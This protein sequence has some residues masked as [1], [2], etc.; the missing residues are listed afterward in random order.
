MASNKPEINNRTP[1]DSLYTRFDHSSYLRTKDD[2]TEK[3]EPRSIV[4]TTHS[5]NVASV[6]RLSNIAVLRHNTKKHH[7]T[8]H[9]LHNVGRA[10]KDQEREDIERYI[11]V[12]RGEIFFSKGVI[13]V[14]GDAEK[15]MLP[16]LAK[17]YD[18][19]FDFDALG[20]TVCSISGTN[21]GPYVQLLGPKGL[22]IPFV[23]LTDFDPKSEE[24]SQEDADP[25][26]AGVEDCYGKN[27][28]VNQIMKSLMDEE[29]WNTTN[30]E[31]IIQLAPTHGVF[32]NTFTFEI[33]LFKAGAH[34]S[35][36]HAV[37]EL[38]TN[39]KMHA[40]FLELSNDS[41]S[42]VPKQFLKDID[43][44][45]KGRMAQRLAAIMTKKNDKAC[46]KYIQDALKHLRE[47]LS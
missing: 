23:V 44:I 2:Q 24:I 47:Q 31:D 26:D 8:G 13:L 11:D 46:P 43:S 38:T 3:T 20:I 18:P 5:P 45:G 12:T 39:K 32:L 21:F 41:N 30:F 27:R 6:A 22:G 33:D 7:T 40:R 28:V 14:E 37:C 1:L 15:F 35:Y 4:L 16:T 17:L 36:Y 9:S 25:D 34:T 29:H 10:L 19:S 42:L